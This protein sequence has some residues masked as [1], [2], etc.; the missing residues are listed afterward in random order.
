MEG[1]HQTKFNMEQSLPLG[2]VPESQR[3]LLRG[4]DPARLEVW[5]PVAL[6]AARNYHDNML[7]RFERSSLPDRSIPRS[8]EDEMKTPVKFQAVQDTEVIEPNANTFVDYGA[9]AIDASGLFM[10]DTEDISSSPAVFLGLRVG[11]SQLIH[12]SQKQVNQAD[13][14]NISEKEIPAHEPFLTV[15]SQEPLMENFDAPKSPSMPSAA[16]SS[17][18]IPVLKSPA[19]QQKAPEV[20]NSFDET[21]PTLDLLSQQSQDE[22]VIKMSPSA[23]LA[24]SQI[25]QP[26]IV[27][28]VPD[29]DP[30]LPLR[31]PERN[32][33]QLTLP[34]SHTSKVPSNLGISSELHQVGNIGNL[35]ADSDYDVASQTS[36]SEL[37]ET[38]NRECVNLESQF[39]VE[40]ECA[41]LI[42]SQEQD[43]SMMKLDEPHHNDTID[44]EIH[45][46][47]MDL[48]S[49]EA[50]T[51]NQSQVPS[52]PPETE[53][54]VADAEKTEN[55]PLMESVINAGETEGTEKIQADIRPL[56]LDSQNVMAD[57]HQNSVPF[58][59]DI[60]DHVC[61]DENLNS[62]KTESRETQPESGRQSDSGNSPGYI[63]ADTMQF[64]SQEL[65]ADSLS[66]IPSKNIVQS[67]PGENTRL[68]VVDNEM[69]HVE[70]V[71][72]ESGNE[73]SVEVASLTKDS[74]VENGSKTIIAK[75][76]EV[77]SLTKES[78]AEHAPK[79][80]T[81]NAGGVASLNKDSSQ[82]EPKSPTGENEVEAL[83][84]DV[85]AAPPARVNQSG[86][87]SN[88]HDLDST[89]DDNTRRS[90]KINSPL[91]IIQ[92]AMSFVGSAMKLFIPSGVP[93]INDDEVG[94]SE[95]EF[96]EI[97][98]E[99]E[100]PQE[101]TQAELPEEPEDNLDVALSLQADL[102]IQDS[103]NL[104]SDLFDEGPT[105]EMF[106]EAPL[107]PIIHNVEKDNI[108]ADLMDEVVNSESSA[109]EIERAEKVDHTENSN[110]G[111]DIT[112]LGSPKS[113]GLKS[114]IP[115]EDISMKTDLKGGK[116]EEN[117]SETQE[118]NINEIMAP[119]TL[120]PQE[121]GGSDVSTN[122][123]FL[124][125]FTD[126]DMVIKSSLSR[127]PD[128]PL[129]ESSVFEGYDN[130][131]DCEKLSD[132]P[133]DDATPLH[134]R[135]LSANPYHFL[136]QSNNT[137]SCNTKT[138]KRLQDSPYTSLK[139][140]PRLDVNM[141]LRPFASSPLMH[142]DARRTGTVKRKLSMS[143]E[144]G[145]V[146]DS[147]VNDENSLVA[148]NI[149]DFPGNWDNAEGVDEKAETAAPEEMN[150]YHEASDTQTC[151]KSIGE[152]WR[153]GEDRSVLDAISIKP[154][155]LIYTLLLDQIL[156]K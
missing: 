70:R 1:G 123:C 140:R 144:T 87:G 143:F 151:T 148:G 6:E 95:D 93:A 68:D 18:Q 112:A 120:I 42:E 99:L 133:L 71:Q 64:C 19:L 134:K 24:F 145:R 149:G 78:D 66:Q 109:D 122:S 113:A 26:D 141:P 3:L 12:G 57:C 82:H 10:S 115:D 105:S 22:S 69:A 56:D 55:P 104:N 156:Q 92:T 126:Q 35:P 94:D 90:S 15:E 27:N 76:L 102:V 7:T 138:K 130:S 155:D 88:I 44:T 116:E 132:L 59:D 48:C 39:P 136:G 74:D 128:S 29:E 30:E 23:P 21:I 37:M 73:N 51:D 146:L 72:E 46:E 13:D 85:G 106:C 119:S 152:R 41:P 127:V 100:N 79:P 111:V 65:M 80:E 96:S 91:G 139:K 50:I 49:Q 129:H 8:T 86:D 121:E 52:C 63:G 33:S 117:Y 77:E 83:A 47:P 89:E 36:N 31:S 84:L 97:L 62:Q 137:P 34:D 53:K 61:E 147:Q 4:I 98:S 150:I 60:P 17:R 54:S 28:E 38:Q 131:V 58:E 2:P 103:Q 81:V 153:E 14:S 9:A 25:S 107:Q 154:N 124:D 43:P 142:V 67:E 11:D 118:S 110:L 32:L 40:I 20:E 135:V 45:D 75:V 5:I 114:E 16:G 125:V 101:R 108:E